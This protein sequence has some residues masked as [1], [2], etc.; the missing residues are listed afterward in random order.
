MIAATL[1]GS[2]SATASEDFG[3][4]AIQWL[5]EAE[6][7]DG[8]D[9]STES[10]EGTLS[11]WESAVWIVRVLGLEP[12]V[13]EPFTDVAH[14]ASYAGHVGRLYRA[15]ITVGCRSDPFGF[16][17][18]NETSRAQMASFLTRAFDLPEADESAGFE[19]VDA[20]S[21]HASNI[22]ALYAA[23][24]TVGCSKE[25]KNYCP[26][27]EISYRQAAVM[28]YRAVQRQTVLDEEADDEDDDGPGR[29]SGRSGSSGGSSSGSGS[30]SGTSDM[31]TPTT[32]PPQARALPEHCHGHEL[33]A[34]ATGA[35]HAQFWHWEG[36][37][38][39]AHWH[40]ADTNSPQGAFWD[41]RDIDDGDDDPFP[42]SWDVPEHA[43]C[44][45]C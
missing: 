44:H 7:L 28:L 33:C 4:A 10:C 35:G 36:A 38:A 21:S 41:W 9:C 37:I 8:T 18:D 31:T 15:D 6:V 39:Y 19:D 30:G 40:N 45:R 32:V 14:D 17:P 1:A 25:P 20:D 26:N 16:C 13:R 2:S 12:T 42:Q 11:R 22:D 34:S 27:D 24:I 23:G 43:H 29:G 3:A 5:D